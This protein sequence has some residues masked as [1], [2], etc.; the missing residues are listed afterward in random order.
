MR[1]DSKDIDAVVVCYAVLLQEIPVAK[2]RE[3]QNLDEE[4][5]VEAAA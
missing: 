1:S 4:L 3:M 2:Q 5:V